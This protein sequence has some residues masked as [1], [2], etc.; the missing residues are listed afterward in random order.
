MPDEQPPEST[1]VGFEAPDAEA[2]VDPRLRRLVERYAALIGGSIREV[3]PHLVELAVPAD[4]AAHFRSRRQVKVALSL[5]ALEQHPEAE[6]PVV[7]GAFLEELIDAVR[8]HG[9]RR[10]YGLIPP[11]FSADLQS[12]SLSVPIGGATAGVP[13]VGLFL[14]PLGR[15]IARVAL[16]AG[17]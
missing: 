6:L 17:A 4:Q 2:L 9:T 11:A 14:H 16:T 7:G 13:S 5:G 1:Q 15:L 10:S 12:V 3:E 8:G